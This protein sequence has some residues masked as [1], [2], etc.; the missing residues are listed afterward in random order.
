M[1]PLVLPATDPVSIL[2]AARLLREG[3]VVAIPTDTVYGL[4]A[5]VFQAEA[6]ERVYRLKQRPREQQVPVL[7]ATAADLPVLVETIPGLAWRLI[8]HF[9]PGALTLALPTRRPSPSLIGRGNRTI[10][11]RMPAA[12]STLELLQTLGEPVVG[13]SAN[14]SGRPSATT[15]AQVVAEL[16]G[17]DAVLVDDGVIQ[18]V[19]STVVE[20]TAQ[21]VVV[22]REGAVPVRR[23]REVIGTRTLVRERLVPPQSSR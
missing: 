16:P 7:F 9:W 17:V 3:G 23:L 6:I 10:G 11:V 2:T 8:E 1:N 4:A 14:V 22:H 21:G 20:V 15:A 18:G 5:S 13:T 19:A 12:R